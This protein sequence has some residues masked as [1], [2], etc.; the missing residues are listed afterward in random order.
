[1]RHPLMTFRGNAVWSSEG[2]LVKARLLRATLEGNAIFGST[3]RETWDGPLR[4]PSTA[5][6]KTTVSIA[7]AAGMP[8][9]TL[10]GYLAIAAALLIPLVSRTPARSVA[11]FAIICIAVAWLQMAFVK[12]GGYGAHHTILLWPLPAIGIAAVLAAALRK[13]LL[14]VII[15]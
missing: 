9:H 5:A 7:L 14:G 11:L 15:T 3:I 6:E 12:D 2:L 1:I 10:S 4:E 8:V 13:A